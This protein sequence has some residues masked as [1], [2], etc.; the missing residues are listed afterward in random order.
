MKLTLAPATKKK[1]DEELAYIIMLESC[2][3]VTGSRERWPT[4]WSTKER[5]RDEPSFKTCLK[6]FTCAFSK[7]QITSRFFSWCWFLQ[8]M[9]SVR[10]SLPALPSVSNI[11]SYMKWIHCSMPLFF[12]CSTLPAVIILIT[13]TS[14]GNRAHGSMPCR[15]RNWMAS[16]LLALTAQNNSGSGSV[17]IFTSAPLSSNRLR[18]LSIL[19]SKL[20]QQGADGKGNNK[21][22][23]ISAHTNHKKK[24]SFQLPKPFS[25]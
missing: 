19:S 21:K 1:S 24:L 9:V 15:R 22:M 25:G 3:V 20:T 17:Q 2:W 4:Q 13:R 6:Y 18:V 10:S 14:S 23:L 8:L 16:I 12:L 5:W 7:W 11:H